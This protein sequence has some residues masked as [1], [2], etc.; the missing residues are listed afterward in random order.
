VAG[1]EQMLSKV[2]LIEFF[3]NERV[4][5]TDVGLEA[6]LPSLPSGDIIFICQGHTGIR[7]LAPYYEKKNS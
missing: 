7:L 2:T 6:S 5:S 3:K 1:T 4:C